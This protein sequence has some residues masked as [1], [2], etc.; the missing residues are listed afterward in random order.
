MGLK[1]KFYLL[2]CRMNLSNRRQA[3]IALIIANLIW[4][5]ASPIFKWSLTSIPPF[6]LA[7]IRFLFAALIILPFAFKEFKQIKLQI[8]PKVVI[9]TLLG[10]TF[11]IS[12]YFL[13][14]KL[15][16]SINAA[17]IA[18]IQPFILVL[19]GA[20]FLKETITRREVIA[21][22]VS[23][24]GI[25]IIIIAPLVSNGHKAEMFLIGN[26]F[27]LLATM[28]AIGH[29]LVSKKV[30]NKDN[31]FGVTFASFLIG[32]VT[33]LPFAFYEHL[34]NPMWYLNLGVSGYVGIVYGAFFSSALAYW[35]YMVGLNNM[36]ASETGIFG[37]IMPLSAIVVGIVFFG[38]PLTFPFLIGSI[39]VF[40]GLIL[41]EMGFFRSLLHKLRL[42]C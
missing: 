33:F 26:V 27:F 31:L 41:Q 21:A 18:S 13:G 9:F 22:M 12:F 38:E 5:A 32:S 14:L 20:W 7:F 42:I 34:Q 17:I 30:L 10:V 4:G 40:I 6:L 24:L 39:F 11:N 3:I 25:L 36:E 19:M 15:A 37:Y 8:L 29:A 23:F 1:K 35:L 2:I 16:P 28:G